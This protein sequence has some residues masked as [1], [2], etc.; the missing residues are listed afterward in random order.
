MAGALNP[1]VPAIRLLIVDDHSELRMMIV[2]MLKRTGIL[3][4]DQAACGE[5]CLMMTSAAAY[6]IILLDLTM[7]GI[8]GIETCLRLRRNPRN[9]ATRIVACTAHHSLYARDFFEATGFNDILGKP[10]SFDEL[11]AKVTP[12][13]VA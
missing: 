6:S 4:I 11:V 10:F 5:E 1:P 9:A 7:P 12:K 2:R 13:V 8:G 3:D